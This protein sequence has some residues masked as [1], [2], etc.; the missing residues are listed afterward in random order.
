MAGLKVRCERGA[1]V[2]LPFISIINSLTQRCPAWLWLRSCQI[3]QLSN[4]SASQGNSVTMSGP[5]CACNKRR[6]ISATRSLFLTISGINKNEAADITTLRL[7]PNALSASSIGVVK[8]PLT[9]CTPQSGYSQQPFR[10]I[11]T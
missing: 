9:A 4:Y 6:R 3:R 1:D 8:L 11:L 2:S 10:H 7:C 5:E